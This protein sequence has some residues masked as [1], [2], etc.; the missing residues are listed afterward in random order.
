MLQ[1]II[2]RDVANTIYANEE[3]NMFC[4]KLCN[5]RHVTYVYLAEFPGVARGTVAEVL[6]DPV[7]ADPVVHAGVALTVVQVLVT[8]TN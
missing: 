8:V 1:N 7:H 5:I 6:I 2:G 4:T 3:P